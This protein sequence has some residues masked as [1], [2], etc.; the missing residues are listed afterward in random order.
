MDL[1][2]PLG[3]AALAVVMVAS[4]S[5]AWAQAEV[6][7]R[8]EDQDRL[9]G[10]DRA[11]GQALRQLLAEGDAAQIALATEAL[12]GKPIPTGEVGTDSLA[13]EWSCR[14]TKIGGN[15]PAVGYPPFRCRFWTEEGRV[16]FE[17]LT[18]SQR[19]RGF[20]RGE[21]GTIVYL[22]STFV[23]GE[24]PKPYADFPESV[25]LQST[26][27]LPDAG[28]FEATGPNSARILFPLPYRESVLNVLTLSR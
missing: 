26:E 7:I 21:H 10:L 3:T 16:M 28:I 6:P 9:N 19:T 14:M 11:A 18:G 23:E 17:K 15:L 2:M 13:G 1:P 8:S 5:L 4:A 27:T 25:D 24:Q 22:G 12:R 20:L